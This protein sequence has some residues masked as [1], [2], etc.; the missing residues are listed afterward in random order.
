MDIGATLCKRSKPECARCPL[1]SNCKA[2]VEDRVGEFPHRKAKKTLPVRKRHMLILESDAGEVLLEKRPPSG[3]W[4]GLLAL[5]IFDNAEALQEWC[6][7]NIE[8][9]VQIGE[10]SLTRHT[11]SHFRMDITPV[12]CRIEARPSAIMEATGQVWYKDGTSPGG[13][14]APVNRLLKQLFH[15][16]NTGA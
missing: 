3:I 1:T 14:P 9:V 8:G 13:I 7:N 5:P 4:G 12:H 11:F 2:F 16:V 10:W 6:D 15:Q